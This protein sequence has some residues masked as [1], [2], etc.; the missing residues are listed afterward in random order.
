MPKLPLISGIEVVKLL[1][2]I[3]YE[4]DHQ[5]GSHLILRQK[6]EPYRRLT[7]PNH[8]QIAKGTLRAII[9]QAGLTREEFISKIK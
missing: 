6:E 3:G 7:V 1:C 4:I 5:T 2:K 9:R 8:R